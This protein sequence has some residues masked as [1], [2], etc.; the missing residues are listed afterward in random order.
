MISEVS[1]IATRVNNAKNKVSSRRNVG[2]K[3]KDRRNI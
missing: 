3:E 1:L 2:R